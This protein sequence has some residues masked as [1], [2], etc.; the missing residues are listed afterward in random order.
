MNTRWITGTGLLTAAFS[1]ALSVPFVPANAQLNGGTQQRRNP[2]AARRPAPKNYI[3][4]LKTIADDL[5]K[6]YSVRVVVDPA[7]FI[8]TPPKAPAENLS[9]EQAMS[10]LAVPLKDIAWRRVYFTQAQ[11]NVVPAADRLA[12]AVRALDQVEQSGLVLENP[13][14]KQAT[15]FMKNWAVTPT[16]AADL[17][18][19]QFAATPIYVIYAVNPADSGK[20]PMDKFSDLQRQSMEMM[21]NMDPDQMGEAMSRSMDMIMNMD[22]DTRSRFMGMQMQ[23]GMKMLQNMTPEQRNELMQQ[24]MKMFQQGGFGIPGGPGGGGNGRRP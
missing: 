19:S 14:T 20:S 2:N 5:S 10:T 13:T 16:F 17:T 9:V 4:D 12:M 22:P 11:G 8:A 21:M 6:R 18:A 1:L 3:T 15:T 24:S 7:L 23:A